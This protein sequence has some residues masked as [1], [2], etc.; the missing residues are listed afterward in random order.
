MITEEQIN[1]LI[2]HCK[3]QKEKSF[4]LFLKEEHSDTLE[5]LYQDKERIRSILL[6]YLITT[7]GYF[8]TKRN[9]TTYR[10]WIIVKNTCF[11]QQFVG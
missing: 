11:V 3:R 5:C 2:E 4:S 9:L 8:V 1:A 7:K 6:L 10:L